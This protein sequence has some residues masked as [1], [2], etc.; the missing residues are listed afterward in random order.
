[1][2]LFLHPRCPCSRAT[3]S[4]LERLAAECPNK[5]ALR[6]VFVRP[7]STPSGWEQTDLYR[8]AGSI[9]QSVVS[10]DENAVEARRFGAATSGQTLLYA[11]DG[12]LLFRGG[13]TPSRGHE[14][15]NSGRS[16]LASLITTGH[17]TTTQTAVFGCSLLDHST[18]G[19]TTYVSHR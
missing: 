4:E 10:I 3:V 17:S 12:R 18:Q 6:I 8:T 13:I 5:F 7:P 11:V 14:G 15:D 16:A 2:V 19:Q 9:P 1:L